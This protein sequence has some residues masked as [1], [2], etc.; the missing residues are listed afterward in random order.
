MKNNGPLS[1]LF[2]A[3]LA[4]WFV[5]SRIPCIG[6]CIFNDPSSFGSLPSW[7]NSCNHS[8]D[9][10]V[11]TNI[12][13]TYLLMAAHLMRSMQQTAMKGDQFPHNK[14]GLFSMFW[15]K[16][17]RNINDYAI[18]HLRYSALRVLRFD[19][20][21]SINWTF[22]VVDSLNSISAPNSDITWASS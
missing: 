10:C 15:Y 6:V 19:G 13:Q 5:Y 3:C 18:F 20:S 8:N 7:D 9:W 16:C 21:I 4:L 12:W 14:L 2:L 1:L 22:V 11:I 17:C